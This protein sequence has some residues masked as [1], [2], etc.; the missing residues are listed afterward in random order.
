MATSMSN[1]SPNT[2]RKK[3]DR[4]SRGLKHFATMVCAKVQ[5]KNVTTYS[6][7]ADELVVQHQ[8]ELQSNPDPNDDGEPKNIRR[9]VYD[10]LNVLMALNIISKDKKCIRWEGLPTNVTQEAR[11]YAATKRKKEEQ[12]QKLKKQLQALVLQHIAFQNLIKRNQA[13]MQENPST[14]EHDSIQLPFVIVSTRQSAVIDCQM[15]ADQSEYFF[16]F[17]EPFVIHDDLQV[18]SQLGLTF[19]LETGAI[20]D[21]QV[22]LARD[23]LPAEM[24]HILDEMV[25]EGRARAPQAPATAAAPAPAATASTAATAA[26]ASATASIGTVSQSAT[27]AAS[28]KTAAA[29]RSA[30]TSSS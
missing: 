4:S 15:A 20:S 28:N 5:E 27:A 10:A 26:T 29:A 14:E 23:L 6:E 3:V 7:V 22:A 21:E 17:N 13:R 2:K 1:G 24:G 25:Q 30:P 11:T 12:V 16:D 8:R 19:G 18:L 9:R